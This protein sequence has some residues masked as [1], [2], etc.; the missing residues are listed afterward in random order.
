MT[1]ALPAEPSNVIV[2]DIG[3]VCCRA[4]IGGQSL[5]T[6]TIPYNT[7]FLLEGAAAYD[8]SLYLQ[9]DHQ[10][11]IDYK[12][13]GSYERLRRLLKRLLFE[14]F[15]RHLAVDPRRKRILFV[16]NPF[17]PVFFKQALVE[18]LFRVFDISSVSFVLSHVAGLHAFGK[19]SGLVVECGYKETTIIPIYDGRP[20]LFYVEIVSVG[21]AMLDEAVWRF[22]LSG[23]S[24]VVLNRNGQSI[25][26]NELGEE[27]TSNR[28]LVAQMKRKFCSFTPN[29]CNSHI[30]SQGFA[31]IAYKNG[32]VVSFCLAEFHQQVTCA[33]LRKDDEER[34]IAT[35]I[36]DSIYK[37]QRDLR[38][39]LAANIMFIGGCAGI[40]DFCRMIS[41]QVQLELE[42]TP[43]F[44]AFRAL[45]RSLEVHSNAFPPECTA[46]SGGSLMAPMRLASEYSQQDWQRGEKVPDWSCHSF[47]AEME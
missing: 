45:N 9:Q 39:L 34:S 2:L 1:V 12:E 15:F 41:S 25:P 20:C 8:F 42:K 40:P 44:A 18:I 19:V 23:E 28:F 5:P 35:A 22:L 6:V 16:E 30:D 46:W 14:L 26:F 17:T 21:G 7:R 29:S 38:P 36:C 43:K 3:T 31:R 13:E 4:G 24:C 33:L 32:L 27:F 11:F 47:T 10:T 37:S